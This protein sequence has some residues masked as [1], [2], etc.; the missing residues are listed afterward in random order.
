MEWRPEMIKKH[1][2]NRGGTQAALVFGEITDP[3]ECA[4][5][6]ARIE[7]GER[8][9]AWLSEHWA[10]FLPQ[11]RGKFIAVAGQEGHI[12]DSSEE[13][14]AWARSAH[15][16]DEGALVQ[17]VRPQTGPRIYGNRR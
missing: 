3:V 9:L 10:D 4:K 7:Q 15:P 13:A 14:W 1:E 12:A 11:V 8:N 2:E 5:I 16:E 17:F 6:H